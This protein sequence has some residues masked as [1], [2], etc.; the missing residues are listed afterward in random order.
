VS[1]STDD[2]IAEAAQLPLR[3]AAYAIWRQKSTFERLEGRVWPSRDYSTPEA[4][5][6]SRQASFAQIKHERDFAQDGPSFD[7]L[8]RAHPHAADAELKAVIVAAVKFDA[9]CFRY[10][11][12][13]RG[14]DYLENVP[15]AVAQAARHNAP[16][17]ETTY[18]DAENWVAYNMK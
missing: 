3:D 13:G 9:D 1:R 4:A 7:R 11:S 5:E 17:L 14:A 8:K 16:Y 18:R 2:L 12:Y 15:H 6:K 10:F